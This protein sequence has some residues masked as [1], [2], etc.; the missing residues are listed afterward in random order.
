M[1]RV[2]LNHHSRSIEQGSSSSDV[3]LLHKEL[4]RADIYTRECKI[5][6]DDAKAWTVIYDIDAR[7]WEN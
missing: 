5:D 7:D 4:Y 2:L 6:R 1:V 3:H